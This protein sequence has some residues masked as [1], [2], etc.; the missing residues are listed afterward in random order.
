MVWNSLGS[1]PVSHLLLCFQGP[2]RAAPHLLRELWLTSQETS[3]A[4]G[5][6]LHHCRPYH[7]VAQPQWTAGAVSGD[8]YCYS[9][10]IFFFF[11]S[12][13]GAGWGGAGWGGGGEASGAHVRGSADWVK[14]QMKLSVIGGTAQL[15]VRDRAKMGQRRQWRLCN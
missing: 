4:T 14:C 9:Q 2:L 10:F 3:P 1:V 6:N 11:L 15:T 12:F 5:I 7:A 8:Y 13:W